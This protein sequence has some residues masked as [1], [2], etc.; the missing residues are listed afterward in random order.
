MDLNSLVVR[1]SHS[2]LVPFGSL[3]KSMDSS[4]NDGFNKIHRIEKEANYVEMQPY[5][6]TL[7]SV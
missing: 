5:S 2:F 3:V 7:K 1:E 4:Q 6:Q